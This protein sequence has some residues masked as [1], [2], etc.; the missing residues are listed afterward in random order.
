MGRI[1]AWLDKALHLRTIPSDILRG[2]ILPLP[3]L[4]VCIV[5]LL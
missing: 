2:L 4:K 3:Y 1:Y 5:I